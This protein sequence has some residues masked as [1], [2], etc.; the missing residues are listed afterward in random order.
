MKEINRNNKYVNNFSK[1]HIKNEILK[2]L[3]E[4]KYK[5]P[6]EIQEKCIPNIN[7]NK[8]IIGI[9]KTGSG[10]TASFVLPI[11]NKI[12][13]KFRYI[14]SMVLVPTRELVIQVNN[15]FKIFSKYLSKIITLPLYGGQKY[16]IQLNVLKYKYPQIIIATPGRLLD[17]I[18]NNNI[19]L[20]KL[21]LL[22]LD[23]ADEMLRMG[24]IKDV[25][26]II[27]H[28]NK[29]CQYILFSATIS[30][31][32]KKIIYSLITNPVEI[33]ISNKI[34]IPQSIKQYYCLVNFKVKFS[35]LIKFLEVETFFSIIIFV[36]TKSFTLELSS[37]IKD[38]GYLCSPLNGDMNQ[39]LREK[40][41]NNF[42]KGNIT[43]LVATDIASRGL[44]IENVDLIINY[45][46]PL[47]VECYI[48][49]I[50]RTGRAGKSG[51]SITFIDNY[52]NKRFIFYIKKYTKSKIEKINIP[53]KEELF[54][55][56]II[57]F[58]YLI[59]ETLIK[60][61]DSIFF[62]KK[63]LSKLINEYNLNK[64]NI[65]ISLITLI[66]KKLSFFIK[67]NR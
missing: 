52:K 18:K 49:R 19:N 39:Y 66:Y 43:I 50:G 48:H 31:S 27:F 64:D 53:H 42:R 33:N 1:F 26:K 58:N 28:I 40:V 6:T 54:N 60:E 45:D 37:K 16:N 11:L 47:D 62:Y 8:N 12:N 34:N 65:T 63:I 30:Y 51:K 21:N 55:N 44:D 7:L 29:K 14:Q 36:K 4:I 41:L 2:V 35:T 61:K 20:S 22:V 56:K 5:I 10:K 67:K 23:E 32:I 24:F 25:K 13:T 17:H 59:K 15:S 9:A 3:D 46:L 57:K 38:I